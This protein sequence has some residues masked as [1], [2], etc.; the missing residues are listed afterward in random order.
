MK[1]KW[2]VIGGGG[3][4]VVE[5]FAGVTAAAGLGFGR[6]GVCA[7]AGGFDAGATSLPVPAAPALPG[8]PAP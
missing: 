6:F 5:A 2:G 8:A 1:I 4:F 3:G 7:D